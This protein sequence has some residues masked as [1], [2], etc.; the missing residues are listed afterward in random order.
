MHFPVAQTSQINGVLLT[1]YLDSGG[2]LPENGLNDI[3]PDAHCLQT[4]QFYE[5]AVVRGLID[6]AVLN[7]TSSADY[8]DRFAGRNA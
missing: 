2:T 3:D 1:Q 4:L 5:Q 8:Q 7:Y 6:P